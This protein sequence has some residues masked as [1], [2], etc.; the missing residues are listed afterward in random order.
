[1]NG[2]GTYPGLELADVNFGNHT[3][4][5]MVTFDFLL[6]VVRDEFVASGTGS[7]TRVEQQIQVVNRA[8]EVS[9]KC[10][11]FITTCINSLITYPNGS[12]NDGASRL[13]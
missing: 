12:P 5:F 13:T 6:E 2:S 3:H 4:S 1:M 9:K 8:I 10:C 11:T 7:E